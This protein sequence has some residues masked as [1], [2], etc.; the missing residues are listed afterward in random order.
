MRDK[1]AVVTLGAQHPFA[2][3]H[4]A[5]LAGFGADRNL[6]PSMVT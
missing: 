4:I 6:F 2:F 5:F 3:L 1:P